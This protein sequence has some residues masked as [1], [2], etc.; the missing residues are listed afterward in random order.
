MIVSS[1]FIKT[2][3]LLLCVVIIIS[4]IIGIAKNGFEILLHTS[5]VYFS[6]FITK[7]LL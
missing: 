4:V 3:L 5:F 1:Y 7:N 6:C 2:L